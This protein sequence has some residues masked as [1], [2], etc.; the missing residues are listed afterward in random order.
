MQDYHAEFVEIYN[1]KF[2]RYMAVS[3]ALDTVWEK[4]EV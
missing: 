3:N 4:F 2:Q 1:K